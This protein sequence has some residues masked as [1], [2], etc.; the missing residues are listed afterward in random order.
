MTYL[1]LVNNPSPAILIPGTR[2]LYA[3]AWGARPPQPGTIT[4]RG[5]KN[6]QPVFDVELDNGA[7]HWGYTNQFSIYA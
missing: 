3:G 6:G 7:T 1:T 4:G 2:V 5:E